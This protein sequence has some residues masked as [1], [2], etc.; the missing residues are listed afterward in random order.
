MIEHI[1]LLE[2]RLK[3]EPKAYTNFWNGLILAYTNANGLHFTGRVQSDVY[4]Y[5]YD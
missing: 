5:E 2:N 1:M 4:W 3:D